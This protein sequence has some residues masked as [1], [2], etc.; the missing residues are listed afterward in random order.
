M[1][2]PY[3]MFQGMQ[4]KSVD[5]FKEEREVDRKSGILADTGRPNKKLMQSFFE[6]NQ[7][8][9]EE[10]KK[11]NLDKERGLNMHLHSGAKYKDGVL[12][13]TRDGINNLEG[14]G[15][16]NHKKHNVERPRT[17]EDI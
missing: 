3:K 2:I 5:R 7:K 8:S 12:K 15:E 6:K 17:F 4:K 11:W 1:K 9:K 13:L 16:G 14:K 10:M